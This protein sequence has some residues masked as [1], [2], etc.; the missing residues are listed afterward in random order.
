MHLLLYAFCFLIFNSSLYH[1]IVL[2]DIF[3]EIVRYRIPIQHIHR[4]VGANVNFERTLFNIDFA[5]FQ[6][7]NCFT[8]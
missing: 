6:E 7:K 5:G 1:L 8:T 3:L 4:K 2:L